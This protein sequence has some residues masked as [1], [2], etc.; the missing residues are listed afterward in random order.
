LGGGGQG[1]VPRP[2]GCLNFQFFHNVCL[3]ITAALWLL[4]SCRR[5][6]GHR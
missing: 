5:K 2:F 6:G 4:R 3:L 1:V